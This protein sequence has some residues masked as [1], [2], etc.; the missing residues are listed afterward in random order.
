MLG[1]QQAAFL[2][3]S[4]LSRVTA[5]AVAPDG[6][7]LLA[8]E[9]VRRQEPLHATSDI[10]VLRLTA[11]GRPD[12]AFGPGGLRT[13]GFDVSADFNFDRPAALAVLPDGRILVAPDSF[14]DFEGSLLADQFSTFPGSRGAVG[15]GLPSATVLTRQP[16]VLM[17]NFPL[18]SGDAAATPVQ[19]LPVLDPGFLGGVFV[20]GGRY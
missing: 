6:R 2:D 15:N 5:L 3:P 8:G 19:V 16:Q 13:V 17:F 11:D 9:V 1:L 7:V 10:G 14:P 12:E 4:A 18:E 20:G